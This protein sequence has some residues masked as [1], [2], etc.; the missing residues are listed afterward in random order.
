MDDAGIIRLQRD[1]QVAKRRGR[2]Q[3]GLGTKH[4]LE[5]SHLAHQPKALHRGHTIGRHGKRRTGECPQEGDPVSR[6]M[7]RLE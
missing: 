6:Q 1:L 7:G 2:E 4:S 3:D 5:L